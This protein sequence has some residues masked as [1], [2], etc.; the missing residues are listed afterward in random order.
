[1]YLMPTLS[2]IMTVSI[3]SNV[4]VWV[5]CIWANNVKIAYIFHEHPNAE[6]ICST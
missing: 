5:L 4:R 6:N 1:M 3:S 2:Y